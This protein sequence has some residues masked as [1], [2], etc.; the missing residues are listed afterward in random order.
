MCGAPCSAARGEC[1]DV[2]PR[3]PFVTQPGRPVF[4][5]ESSTLEDLWRVKRKVTVLDKSPRNP[6]I[7]RDRAWEGNGPFVMGTV[8]H[9]P[10]DNL[11]KCWYQVFDIEAF[12]NH[13]P[14]SYRICYAT[15]QDGYS[16]EKPDLGL[17][18]WR[19]SKK[20]NFVRLG[21]EFAG[22]VDVH[23][24]P[25]G[26]GLERR[27]VA[28][29]LDRP[30]ICM[31][32]SDDGVDWTEHKFNPIESAH[33]DTHNILLWVASE[34]KWMVYFRPYVYAGEW[35]RRIA[36]IESKDLRT[37]T[38]QSMVLLP[39]EADPLE[40]MVMPVF[41]RGNLFWGMPDFYDRSRGS[42]EVELVFSADGQRWNR[43]PPREKFLPRGPEGDFDCGTVF[44]ASDPVIVGDE[45][46]FYYGGFDFD[47]EAET[48]MNLAIG[49]GSVP[50]DRLFGMVHSSESG[51]G[52]ILTRPL[53][54]RGSRLEVN[55][56][57]SGE[58]KIAILD[59]EGEDI[60]QFGIA[61]CRIIKGDSLRHRV[62]W[63][64]GNLPAQLRQPMRLKFHLTGETTL[65][66]FTIK[67]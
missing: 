60:P 37:W 50:L 31:A 24:A 34:R 16:W 39:D 14:G 58:M 44:P 1:P 32:F 2:T 42:N 48:S 8:L 46:R 36:V 65:Y 41:L 53:L 52:A 27:F 25:P 15:S 51:A 67:G 45:M 23:L 13:R 61:D 35:K 56:S 49:A 55:A 66:A 59:H 22:G 19:G 3:A 17:V 4:L 11:F 47:H 33:S 20:N 5:L 29:Y 28:L 57:V 54:L 38:P 40:I 12:W 64:G 43:V 26:S 6:L 7:I 63:V 62:S 21:R 18:D 9:D 10:Q 30:G